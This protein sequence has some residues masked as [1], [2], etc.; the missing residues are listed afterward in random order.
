MR[1]I[2]KTATILFEYTNFR[3]LRNPGS[4][5]GFHLI[6]DNDKTETIR[7]TSRLSPTFLHGPY[8]NVD[9]PTPSFSGKFQ[10]TLQHHKA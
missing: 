9:L 7:R 5:T 10:V 1:R 2:H 3:M 6:P 8:T 4:T